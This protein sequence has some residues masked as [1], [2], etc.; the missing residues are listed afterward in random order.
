M[1][2]EQLGNREKLKT[3]P[4]FLGGW[5]DGVLPKTRN[6][7]GEAGWWCESNGGKE[8]L[9]IHVYE[10]PV[11]FQP[12]SIYKDRNS[13]CTQGG[14]KKIITTKYYTEGLITL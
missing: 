2:V 8:S 10:M 1:G 4:R 14:Q 5:G 13:F 6:L 9:A 3:T 7:G 12:L 11:L